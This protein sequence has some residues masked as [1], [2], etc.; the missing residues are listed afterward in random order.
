M[1]GTD[2]RWC[3]GH[4]VPGTSP[5][6]R[7][8][9]LSWTAQTNWPTTPKQICIISLIVFSKQI[10]LLYSRISTLE[11]NSCLAFGLRSPQK[12]PNPVQC[13]SNLT[14]LLWW[15]M[16]SVSS[17]QQHRT[18]VS[19]HVFFLAKHLLWQMLQFVNYKIFNPEE[20]SRTVLQ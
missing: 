5:L 16:P 14:V 7:F 18:S 12:T 3:T 8:P 4:P 1:A 15:N 11:C 6:S 20:P 2:P 17:S 9:P 19:V 10:F 13:G